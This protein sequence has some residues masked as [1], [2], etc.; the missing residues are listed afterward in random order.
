MNSRK[1]HRLCLASPVFFPTYGGS[2]LRFKR[3]LPGLRAR[4]LDIR[5][6]TGTPHSKEM[7]AEESALWGDYPVGEF[8]PPGDIDGIP[9]HR[10][11]LPDTKGKRR[12]RTYNRKLLELCD[13][14]DYRPDVLQMVGPLKPLSIPLLR[15]LRAR[16]IPTLYAVTVAPPKPAKRKWY[17]LAQRREIE[18][19]NLLDCIVT[20][21]QPLKEFV[22][23]MG[24]RTRVEIIP[25]GVDLAR[26]RPA[27]NPEERQS[28]RDALGLS[29][30]DT[31][32]TS[33]GGIMPRKGSDLLIEAWANLAQDYPAAHLVLVGPRKDLEQ[34][35][36]RLF[37]RKLENLVQ[38]SGAPRRVH[39]TGLSDKAGAYLRASDIFV[40]PSEREGMPNAVLEAMASRVPTILTPFKG[41]S[42]DLGT[43]GAQYLLCERTAPALASTLRQLLD[44]AQLRARIARQGYD[45]VRQTM[46]LDKSLDR[47]AALYHELAAQGGG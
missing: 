39:F 40:L 3:Y 2:Q 16:G 45:W 9:V 43:A 27:E 26:F 13:N 36:L 47:Y 14:P 19:F 22:R 33:I 41:L 38:G 5:V 46:S 30:E 11:R 28:L 31:V 4:D 1:T 23:A 37:R 17:S 35:G 8:M 29:P 18:L 12:T 7:S 21:N 34:P 15:K 44:D 10:V 6:F 24:I 25:N 32:I 20:N 42:A